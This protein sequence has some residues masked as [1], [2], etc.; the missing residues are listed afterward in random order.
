M[1]KLKNDLKKLNWKQN[2]LIVSLIFNL[3]LVAAGFYVLSNKNTSLLDN[4]GFLQAKNEIQVIIKRDG[5]TAF[6]DQEKINKSQLKG[7]VASLE[8][9][10]SEYFV[11]SE[12][13]NFNDNLNQRYQGIGVRFDQKDNQIVVSRVFDNSPAKD[14]GVLSG[15]VL[16]AVEGQEITGQNINQVV[17]RIRGEEN[18]EVKLSFKRG[19]TKIDKTI[20]RKKIQSDL[21]YLDFTEKTAIIEITSFGENL[22]SKMQKIVSQIKAKGT[23]VNSIIL[24]LRGNTGGIL[25]QSVEVMSYFVEANS[26]ALI[27]KDKDSEVILRTKFKQD[28]LM[29]YKTVVLMDGNTASASE[30]VA[31][32]LRDN[33]GAKL[34]GTKSFGKGVVQRLYNLKNGDQ[35]KLTIAEWFTPKGTAI[36]KVGLIPDITIEDDTN[37]LDRALLE[38]KK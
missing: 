37:S 31:G 5:I 13:D 19:E 2:L 22:D 12:F 36:N 32:S 1:T 14:N 35:L 4:V 33:T 8:D 26:T 25:D 7:I 10:F 27:E 11:A 9:P 38:L 28:N 24:D 18:T 3:V 6:P 16:I 15:D 30:I 17:T 34:I 21:I 29:N 20:T 23:E